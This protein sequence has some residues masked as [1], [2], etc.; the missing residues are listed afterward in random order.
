[1]TKERFDW[2]RL[3]IAVALIA[4]FT[5]SI[6]AEIEAGKFVGLGDFAY[7]LP[8]AIDSY[9]IASVMTRLDVGQAFAVMG[10]SVGGGHFLI[11]M[12]K[13]VEYGA[14]AAAI[15]ILLTV[16]L[17][18]V[19]T[20]M[21]KRKERRETAAAA[22]AAEEQKARGAEIAERA[23][24]AQIARDDAEHA[25]R[26]EAERIEREEA[27]RR[28]RVQAELDR[29]E[30]DA[31][32]ARETREHTARLAAEQEERRL[33]S[34]REREQAEA[35]RVERERLAAEARAREA[36]AKA[37]AEREAAERAKAEASAARAAKPKTATERVEQSAGLRAVPAPKGKPKSASE[38]ARGLA[39]EVV[40]GR[41]SPREA[42][43][44][45]GCDP[46]IIRRAVRELKSDQPEAVNA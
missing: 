26:L 36:E 7:A 19:H 39:P 10:V 22:V 1:M 33:K 11:G 45:I 13:G 27:A 14:A 5:A 37:A 30:A 18:R 6:H 16:V 17:W 21:E 35:A 29:K 42:A 20:L 3:V 15:G 28:A 23:R 31:R 12:K 46:S 34:Q 44:R 25:A 38:Q 43:E 41:I 40:A 4:I 9:V 32:I 8:F 24:L 2:G